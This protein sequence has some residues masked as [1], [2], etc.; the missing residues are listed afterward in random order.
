MSICST[1]NGYQIWWLRTGM[2]CLFQTIMLSHKNI[3][4]GF[5]FKIARIVNRFACYGM[6]E[7]TVLYIIFN[8]TFCY[9]L[10]P[11]YSVSIIIVL[12]LPPSLH[13]FHLINLTSWIYLLSHVAAKL[14]KNYAGFKYKDKIKYFKNQHIKF[15]GK[16]YFS[17]IN[18]KF[19]RFSSYKT[20]I[21]FLYIFY[22]KN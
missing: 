16:I 11:K 12:Y 1:S 4:Y 22:K 15:K 5:S 8:L 20:F 21:Q 13:L 17:L 7:I 2:K 18:Y 6:N 3:G 10:Y 9:V 19:F 14:A